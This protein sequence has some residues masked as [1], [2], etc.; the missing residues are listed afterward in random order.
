M[1]AYVLDFAKATLSKALGS[2]LPPLLFSL[3]PP[4][5]LDTPSDSPWVLHSGSKKDDQ[6]PISVFVFDSVRFRDRLPLA[7]NAL[8][9][10]KTL[11]HPDILRYIDGCETETQII[12][13]TE[14]ISPLQ[15]QLALRSE[16][17]PNLVAF[18]LHKVASVLKFLTQDCSLIHGCVRASSIFVTP[19]GEWK[20]GCLDFVSSLSEENPPLLRHADSIVMHSKYAPPEVAKNSTS[21]L[22][23]VSIHAMDAWGFA[24]LVHEIFN[25]SLSRAEDLVSQ[26]AIPQSLYRLSQK[27][28]SINPASRPSFEQF[29]VAAVRP[30]GYF[31]TDFVKTSLF[32]EQFSLKD[33]QEKASYFSTITATVATFPLNFCKYKILPE[34]IKAL[35][36]GGGG[37]K[38]LDPILKIGSRLDETEFT[39]MIVPFITKLFASPDRAIRVTLCENLS[40]YVVHLTPKLVSDKIFPN[41]AIVREST[42]K[43][44]L[45]IIPKASISAK[46]AMYTFT[47]ILANLAILIVQIKL[48]ERIINGEL[49]RYL[50]RLQADEEP[51]IRTNTTICIGKMASS[52][53]ESVRKKVLA[54]AFIRSLHDPFPP[55]R[56][57]GLLALSGKYIISSSTIEYYDPAELV[58]KIVPSIS[59]LL[60]DPEK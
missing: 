25:G 41:L 9:R 45:V 19:A 44:V 50:A 55:A 29:I 12:I 2:Q 56:R 48:S 18:G 21:I 24:C 47:T 30:N 1:T 26:G 52:I 38:A 49:L 5:P 33:A 15:S 11:R 6:T 8:K 23:S 53:S 28:G 37:A 42:L 14:A 20:L 13:G 36:F 54:T 17:D 58:Q 34:I 51:G 22:R 7:Q 4:V 32:L 59:P 16:S 27:M 43:A 40:D 35:E 10:A 3:G 57:A 39:T 46:T 60:L 31:D